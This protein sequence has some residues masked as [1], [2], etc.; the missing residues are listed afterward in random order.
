VLE[1]PEPPARWWSLAV[2]DDRGRLIPNAADRYAFNSSNAARNLDGSL[3]M[4]LAR[5]ARPGNWLPLGAGGRIVLI[6]TMHG[7]IDTIAVDGTT[8]RPLE[9]PAIRRVQCA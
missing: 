5:E 8:S 3:T 6:L 1:G 4:S 7:M 2:F 9:L